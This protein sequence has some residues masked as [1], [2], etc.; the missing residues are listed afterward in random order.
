MVVVDGLSR[1][2]KDLKLWVCVPDP[3][4]RLV[5]IGSDH[6]QQLFTIIIIGLLSL[7]STF[8]GF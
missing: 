6:V 4:S 1:S 5:V 8:L 2:F 3:G 7:L